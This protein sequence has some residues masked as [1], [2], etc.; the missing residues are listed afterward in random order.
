MPKVFLVHG[1]E[2]NPNN[3]FFPWLKRELEDRDYEVESLSMPDP[4]NPRM[5][6]WIPHLEQAVG[7]PTEEVIVVGHSMGGATAL[8]FLERLPEGVKIDK[9]VL[10]APAVDI[11]NGLTDE[12][13]EFISPWL[14]PYNDNKIAGSA[15]KIIGIF[16]DNDEFIPLSSA[17]YIKEHFGAETVIDHEM[18]HY[19]DENN[20]T[21][22][23]SV[24]K[25]IIEN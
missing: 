7:T 12:E 19:S 10:V 21:E 24:L 5:E 20:V 15:N 9:A 16:S 2:G 25:A 11:I 18:G 8:R 14:K 22:A 23:P 3:S 1:W 17:D 6:S 13:A 4:D